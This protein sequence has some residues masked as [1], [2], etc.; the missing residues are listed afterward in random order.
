MACLYKLNP[1]TLQI[2]YWEGSISLGSMSVWRPVQSLKSERK[3]F[4]TSQIMCVFVYVRLEWKGA[5]AGKTDS[6][7]SGRSRQKALWESK[8]SHF[9]LSIKENHW[10]L[11]ED[12]GINHGEC[13]TVYF[14]NAVTLD[15]NQG[16]VRADNL[17]EWWLRLVADFEPNRPKIFRLELMLHLRA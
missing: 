16:L 1:P 6:I 14:G 2:F 17:W 5:A 15:P 4:F 10:H 9:E 7:F 13:T 12:G 11:P 8:E 3:T